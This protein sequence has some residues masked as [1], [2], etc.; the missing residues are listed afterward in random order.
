VATGC[1]CFA[2]GGG[3]YLYLLEPHMNEKAFPGQSIKVDE[4][5]RITGFGVDSGGIDL[6]DYLAARAMPIAYQ[7]WMHDY[8][9]P[10]HEDAAFR[11]S[12]ERADFRGYT[13]NL[14]AEDA[15]EMADAMLKA[16]SQGSQMDW[17]Y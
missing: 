8:Y 16:R 2:N 12:D 5:A 17:D 1:G 15:Y 6:R 13:Q 7:F 11:N 14:I 4:N 9:H 10:A 3:W